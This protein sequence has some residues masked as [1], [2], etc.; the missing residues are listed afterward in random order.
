LT[1]AGPDAGEVAP[2]DAVSGDKAVEPGAGG[3]AERNVSSAGEAG[4]TGVAVPDARAA[5]AVEVPARRLRRD[6]LVAACAG[7]GA[8]LLLVIVYLA[9]AIPGAW[10]P[11][12]GDRTY[13]ATAL[14]L[15]DG[16]GALQDGAL[17]VTAPGA[18]DTTIVAVDTDF[19]TSD[20][21]GV[22]WIVR[23]V[24]DG[25][26]VRMLWK[27][28]IATRRTNMAPG[29]V[30]AG[31]I[32]P[33]V[34][35]RD[36]AWLGRVTGIALAIRT[37]LAGP[38]RIEG[39]V[40]RP[41]GVL[42]LARARIGEWLRFEPINGATIN[43]IAGGADSQD[44]PLPPLAAAS[45]LLAALV[46]L[47][48][49]RFAPAAFGLG[50]ACTIGGLFVAAWLLVDARFAQ[51]LARQ[52]RVTYAKYAGKTPDERHRAAEDGAL[53]TFVEHALAIMPKT[54]QRV[55]V[56]SDEHYFRGRA[57]WHLY[58]H[59][60]QFTAFRNDIAPPAWMKPG[61]WLL[62]YDRHN[63]QYDAP[64]KMLRWDGNPAV[65]AELKLLE[66]HGAALFLIE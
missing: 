23:G 44:L 26:D 52:T 57:A 49:R 24:P 58:P 13:A 42:D 53:Y 21:P 18:N 27:T 6:A 62:V 66:A 3:V 11:R 14:R 34:L 30:E 36:P 45:V 12:A 51:N 65:H 60:V 47:A 29:V 50:A 28:D 37:P 64:H 19:R 8:A 59:N 46:L 7:L 54:P 17:V 38:L 9:F 43:T 15:D 4:A 35:A 48:L 25:A 55:F 2:D 22:Q 56:A 33:F 39:V 16:R 41:L 32:R 5:A 40:A 1:P 63:V 61:D 10:F 31:A 20:Y